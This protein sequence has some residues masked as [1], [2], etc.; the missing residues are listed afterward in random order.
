MNDTTHL[1]S[2]FT[3]IIGRPNVGKS[4]FLNVVL[5]Q[6]VSIV[7]SKPQTTRNRIVGIKNL[8]SCQIVFL[9]TP[10]IH[11][12]KGKLG[13][14]LVRKAEEAVKD[15]DSIIFMVEPKNPGD[16][17]EQALGLLKRQGGGKPVI[18][19]I[20][21]VDIHDKA[22]LLP[23]IETYTKLYDFKDII[24]ISALRKDG[25]ERVLNAVAE[26][27]PEGPRL[28]PTDM[29]T[30]MPERFMVGE[31]IREKIMR[32]TG[33]EVPHSVA[34]EIA[35]W[36]ERET[37]TV[38]ISAVI[39]VEKEGQKAIIIGN[40]GELLKKIGTSARKEIA[41]LLGTKIFLELWVKV[42]KQW[43]SDEAALMEFG[44]K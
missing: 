32:A 29:I 31:I 12:A 11:R 30:D 20:N 44:L 18:L 6:K 39:Y 42:K 43:R 13:S 5:G 24:P 23:L 37:G 15:V 26:T 14:A 33:E 10:G 22:V 3:A 36:E 19:A 17:E 9:D 38:K 8:E 40:K 27:L 25:I 35:V 4:T 21:K 2:G 7:T 16:E 1:H 41:R 34:V 28:Y